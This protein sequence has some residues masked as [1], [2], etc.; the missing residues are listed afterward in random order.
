MGALI[1][2][3]SLPGPPLFLEAQVISIWCARLHL[4][5]WGIFYQSSHS[6]VLDFSS[7]PQESGSGLNLRGVWAPWEPLAVRTFTIGVG[8][9]VG[10]AAN[11][12]ASSIGALLISDTLLFLQKRDPSAG[13]PQSPLLSTYSRVAMTLPCHYTFLLQHRA[14]A[15]SPIFLSMHFPLHG[16]GR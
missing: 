13:L 5:L 11:P 1:P 6:S 2:G 15:G 10:K 7:I 12:L 16:K 3:H 14:S 4:L 8:G 9:G